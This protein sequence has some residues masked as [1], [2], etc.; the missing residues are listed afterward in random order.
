MYSKAD[1]KMQGNLSP[2]YFIFESIKRLIIS[3]GVSARRIT[4][5]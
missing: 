3:A 5:R 2:D 1:S 4:S